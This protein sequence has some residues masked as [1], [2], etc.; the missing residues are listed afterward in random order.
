ME[1]IN[2][3]KEETSVKILIRNKEGNEEELKN[4]IKDII[5]NSKKVFNLTHDSD[6]D[7]I[8][9]AALLLRYNIIKN[10]K[11]VFFANYSGERSNEAIS[12]IKNINEKN[13]CLIMT[14]FNNITNP[15]FLEALKEF[16]NKGNS[17]ILLDHHPV[18]ENIDNLDVIDAAIF[19]ENKDRCGTDLV[20]EFVI[21]ENEKEE[22][23]IT[24]QVVKLA[25]YSDFYL[26]KNT[27]LQYIIEKLSD[28][29][30]YINDHSKVHAENRSLRK[31]V[32]LFAIG[33]L[34]NS[35]LERIYEKHKKNE[36]KYLEKLNNNLT[37]FEINN[38]K[39]GVGISKGIK[40]NKACESIFD[41]TNADIAIFINE[42][43]NNGS[44]R[45]KHYDSIALARNLGGN[46]HPKASGFSISNINLKTKKGKQEAVE[47]IKKKAEEVASKI[48]KIEE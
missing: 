29:I 3:K 7:G 22:D 47:F 32:K 18:K 1:K 30:D 34:N 25:H 23:K 17:I 24:N 2:E 12:K 28:I 6:I 11:D 48:T 19:G 35:F 5:S 42:K 20:Y 46:G 45:T 43:S 13:S 9:S 39:I 26:Y 33:D 31:L 37:T 41:K 8:A 10:V 16:K 38:I 4:T 21:R 40:S 44:I 14:D 36:I 15:E 27:D